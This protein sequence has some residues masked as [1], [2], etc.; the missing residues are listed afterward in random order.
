MV[1]EPPTTR[2]TPPSAPETM[3]ASRAGRTIRRGGGVMAHQAGLGSLSRASCG[4]S[5]RQLLTPTSVRGGSLADVS[6]AN[7]LAQLPHTEAA[8]PFAQSIM[9]GGGLTHRARRGRLFSHIAAGCLSTVLPA[10]LL[11]RAEPFVI[12]AASLIKPE[13]RASAEAVV[14]GAASVGVP[15][16]LC[17]YAEGVAVH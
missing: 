3:A 9:D 12:S 17:S 7:A 13:P 15:A 1:C 6:R 11:H 2:S 10:L 16:F 5:R 8:W 4:L 14:V